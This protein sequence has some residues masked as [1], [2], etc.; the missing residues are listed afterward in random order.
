M[1]NLEDIDATS[2]ENLRDPYPYY[3]RLR[4][5]APVFRDPKTGI[6]SVSTYDLVLEVNKR[7]K[8][9]SS[10][11]ATRCSPPILPTMRA[12]NGLPCRPCPIAGSWQWHPISPKLQMG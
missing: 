8:I 1:E 6:V 12:I 4:N 7:P 5:E 10:N 11:F 3:A 2:P 9:F